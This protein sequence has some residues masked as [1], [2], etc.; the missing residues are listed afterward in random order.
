MGVTIT[1]ASGD[2]GATGH[3]CD[4]CDGSP[5][6]EI[7]NCPCYADSGSEMSGWN[8]SVST[9]SGTGYWPYFPATSPYVTT[10][11]ATMV[12]DS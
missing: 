1:V 3:Y 12:R 4:F 8:K 5:P 6:Y 7:W 10:V 9:W 2:S 11:G